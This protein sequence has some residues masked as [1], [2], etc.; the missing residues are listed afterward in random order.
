MTTNLPV[1][2]IGDGPACW[3]KFDNDQESPHWVSNCNIGKRDIWFGDGTPEENE[4]FYCPFCGHPIH[5]VHADEAAAKS[6]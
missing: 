6:A 3:W 2:P 5:V 4:F 1:S